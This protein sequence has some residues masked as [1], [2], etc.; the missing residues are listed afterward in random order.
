MT[1]FVNKLTSIDVY[2]RYPLGQVLETYTLDDVCSGMNPCY[3]MQDGE[4]LKVSSS[5]ASLIIDSGKFEI[6]PE[7][8]PPKF[9]IH[10]WQRNAVDFARNTINVVEKKLRGTSILQ[11]Q[12]VKKIKSMASAEVKIFLW[13][14][15]HSAHVSYESIDVRIRKIKSFESVSA[16]NSAMLLNLDYSINS[17][18]EYLEK[19]A[20]FMRKAVNDI[21]AAF[22]QKKHIILMGGKDS[23][24]ISL[25]PKLNEKNW[26]IFSAEPNFTI[27]NSWVLQNDLHVT[28]IFGHDGRNEEKMA[29]FKRKVICSD[30]YTN[31]IHVRYLPTLEKIAR[32]FDNECIFWF[33]SMP[34]RASLYDGSHRK[35]DALI[36]NDQFFNVHLN[37]FPSWQ[38]NIQQTY[39]NYLGCPFISPYYL[40]DMWFELYA[41]L[42]PRIIASGQDY[43]A[44]LGEMLAGRKIVWPSQNPGPAPYQYWHFWFSSYRYYLN[45]IQRQLRQNKSL[46]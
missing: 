16:G 5:V 13:N 17:L 26:Y 8:K 30:L 4:R 36:S 9:F 12:A 20:H 11:S 25:I 33:G 34:R 23:Q 10:P 31:L 45:Y 27:I 38:G 41:H 37:T 21:E 40:K 15:H 6:N 29:D 18:D 1:S 19:S 46:Q 42:D 32:E 24:L 14:P 3:Y 28:K 43:R 39:S 44:R 7:F 2:T 35:P 22:P